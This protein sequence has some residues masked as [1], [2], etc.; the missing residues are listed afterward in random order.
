[1]AVPSFLGRLRSI[2]A[3]SEEFERRHRRGERV[4]LE[5]RVLRPSGGAG[6]LGALTDA[7]R[8]VTDGLVLRVMPESD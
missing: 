1:M 5:I 7:A 2:Q 8:Q 4:T 3:L 6:P